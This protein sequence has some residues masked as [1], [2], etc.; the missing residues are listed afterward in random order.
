[1][2]TKK[3]N[4]SVAAA[5]LAA[6]AALSCS[7]EL[8]RNDAPVE[9]VVTNTQNL[10]QYDIQG[11]TRCG[12]NFATVDLQVI[13]KNP[14]AAG[15][16][17]DV[18]VRRYRVSYARTDGGTQVPAPFVRS[19]DTLLIVGGGAQSVSGFVALLPE[20]LDQAPFAALKV[21]NGGRDPETGRNR[22]RM[23]I[24]LE[25]FGETLAGDE[26]YDVT[27]LPMDFCSG[28]GGCA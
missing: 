26:V 17:V 3:K 28:C 11:G 10:V 19:I 6:L 25:V 13:A 27:R 7:N 20:A 14:T 16:F 22:I 2:N 9:L 12:E 23:D 24:I 15:P 18:R 5:V 8:S 21:I 1:M 4:L